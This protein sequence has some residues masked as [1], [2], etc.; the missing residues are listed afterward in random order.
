MTEKISLFFHKLF[1]R[2]MFSMFRHEFIYSFVKL[3]IKNVHNTGFFGPT[4]V[5]YNGKVKKSHSLREVC[6][7]CDAE[8]NSIQTSER[9]LDENDKKDAKEIE[10]YQLSSAGKLIQHGPLEPKK[11]V[12]DW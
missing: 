4:F 2:H 9:F 10:E 7:V 6:E 5:Q 1:R 3:G 8:G 11:I 12:E